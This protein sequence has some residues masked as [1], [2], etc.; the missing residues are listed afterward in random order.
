MTT[1]HPS[2]ATLLAYVAGSLP[3]P[4]AIV[5]RTHLALCGACRGTAHYDAATMKKV[6]IECMC[7]LAHLEHHIVCDVGDIID[8][9]LPYRFEPPDQPGGGLP[10]PDPSH[11]AARVPGAEVRVENLNRGQGFGRLA[12]FT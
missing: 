11:D 2:E 7:R 12:A 6:Q 10:H 4:H 8:R 1:R 3:A 9:S 5:V